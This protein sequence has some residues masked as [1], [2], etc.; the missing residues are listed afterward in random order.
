M[1]VETSRNQDNIWRKFYQSRENFLSKFFTPFF[2]WGL[3][4]LQWHIQNTS[5]VYW[6]IVLLCVLFVRTS[7]RVE[8]AAMPSMIIEQV[9]RCKKNIFTIIEIKPR[10]IQIC[11]YLSSGEWGHIF[12][13]LEL[14]G[15]HHDLHNFLCT[16]AMMHIEINNR[17]LLN[18]LSVLGFE[19]GSSDC[20]I[21]Y[22]AKSIGASFNTKV[23]V[24]M[25]SFPE[26]SCMVTRRPRCTKRI[27]VL[28]G[29]DAITSLNYC[30]CSYQCSL[31]SPL[32]RCCVL[33][34]KRL[35]NFI[36]CASHSFHVSHNFHNIIE[37]MY[38]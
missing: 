13:S 7:S 22:V 6:R 35:Y 38:F 5:W 29:H 34:I 37:V 33:T 12:A 10:F 18:F 31:P 14:F 24:I 26:N 25:E 16:I 19:V 32:R 9:D 28:T 11:D 20:D 15:L 17:N 1:S 8:Y 2:C 23:V 36:F 30:T 3:S 4:W 21:I 27:P